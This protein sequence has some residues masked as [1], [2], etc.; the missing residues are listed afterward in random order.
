LL[1]LTGQ[2]R[3]E[4]SGLTWAEV[5]LERK[6]ITLGPERTKNSR[7]HEVPLSTQALAILAR[8]PRGALVFGERAFTDWSR[9]ISPTCALR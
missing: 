7:S 5:N 1:L 4:I 6:V 2:R 9:A 3:T 8:Q